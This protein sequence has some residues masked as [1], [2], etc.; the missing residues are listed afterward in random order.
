MA[1]TRNQELE[2][3]FNTLQHGL[4]ETQQEVQQLSATI[5]SRDASMNASVQIVVQSAMAEVK[6][7]LESVVV[8]LCT[9]LKIPLDDDA[10]KKTEGETSAHS[11]QPHHFQRDIRLPRVDVTKF[12]GF[13]PTGWV[14]QMEHYFSLYNI[15]D[16]LAKLRYGVLHLDQERWQWWQWR[17][18]S[19]QGYIAWTQFVAELYE[20]FDTDT[21]HLGRL[22][23]LKQSGTVE[24]FIAAF[25][26]L[27][28]RTEGMTD[29][30][31]RECFISGLKEE[32]RAHVLMARPTTWVEATKKAKEA[33]QIV[34]SQNRK[35]SFFP[36]PKPANPTTP[37]APLKIQKLTRAEMAER[38]LKG[39][40]YNCDD[41][42]F[43]GHKC[44]EQNLFM[45]ISEDIQEDDDD[46]SPVP[47][48]PETSEINPPSDPP[49]EEPIISLNALT[50]FSAPQTLK[51]IGYI[52]H[53]KVIIL[54]DSGSTHNFIHRRI[55]QETHCYIHAVNNFQIMIA[56]GG[57]MKCGGR[58]E[59]VRLQIE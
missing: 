42:Y 12:D 46:T 49:A 7:E 34:S 30:F 17:K 9:K 13:D 43:P 39:L 59:N 1:H 41:K 55:A 16:D 31:F 38:Q 29:A 22:T 6:K 25:E 57:S 35:P 18:T 36:R 11:F 24:E 53:R 19:R 32:V 28:F 10:P 2:S 50:G 48:S 52:K 4:L 33:Q 5:A 15:T 23:K 47:E 44:K 14:T 8:A 27:A 21:N 37:S 54:V 3:R 40:C 58:F 26:R 45:A 20:R 56:N 51:L